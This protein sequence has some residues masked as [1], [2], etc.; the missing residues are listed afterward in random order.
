L[1]TIYP[2]A[3]VEALSEDSGGGELEP[4]NEGGVPPAELL[5]LNGNSGGGE[6][7]PLNGKSVPPAVHGGGEIIYFSF[8]TLT[9]SIR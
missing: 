4:L 7:E 9:D 5:A 3:E 8:F 1:T 6:L 2:L